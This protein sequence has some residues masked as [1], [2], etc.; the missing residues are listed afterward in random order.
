LYKKDDIK[1]IDRITGLGRFAGFAN[2]PFL[3][4]LTDGV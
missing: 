1:I 4:I 3:S 2:L